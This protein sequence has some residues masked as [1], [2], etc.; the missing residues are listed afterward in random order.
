MGWDV[1]TDMEGQVKL[2]YRNR[3]RTQGNVYSG[4]DKRPILL[5][6]R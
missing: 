3:L 5:L 4:A 1:S 6:A 2:V